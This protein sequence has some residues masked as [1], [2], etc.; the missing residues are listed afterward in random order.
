VIDLFSKRNKILKFIENGD[1]KKLSSILNK[2]SDINEKF[3]K[4]DN[5]DEKNWTYLFHTCRYGNSDIV[6]LL[7]KLLSK[8]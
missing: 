7:L 5:K 8:L 4:P 1:L 2:I 3:P 6:E